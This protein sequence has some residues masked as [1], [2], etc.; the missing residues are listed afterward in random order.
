MLQKSYTDPSTPYEKKQREHGLAQLSWIETA[1]YGHH[2]F[3][4]DHTSRLT[5]QII[6]EDTSSFG[7][8]SYCIVRSFTKLNK[9]VAFLVEYCCLG[10]HN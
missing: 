3:T 2:I 4:Q 8:P 5:D 9:R 7:I 1:R 10:R 6:L